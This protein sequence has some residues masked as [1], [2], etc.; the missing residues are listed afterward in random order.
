MSRKNIPL[1][2]FAGVVAFVAYLGSR[3]VTFNDAKFWVERQLGVQAQTPDM[4]SIPYTN[5]GPVI[6]P[7]K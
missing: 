5:Y 1:L 2:L 6:V 7:G 3:G 4:K